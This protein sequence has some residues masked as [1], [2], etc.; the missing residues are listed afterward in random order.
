MEGK[1]ENYQSE[2]SK[3]NRSRETRRIAAMAAGIGRPRV[4]ILTGERE[5]RQCA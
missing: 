5:V 1:K 3:S 4:K 2:M